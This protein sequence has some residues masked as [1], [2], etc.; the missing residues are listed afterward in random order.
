MLEKALPVLKALVTISDD[1]AQL[2]TDIHQLST[3]VSKLS[4]RLATLEGRSESLPQ[5]V[6]ALVDDRLMEVSRRRRR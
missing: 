3:N 1:I 4:E 5:V 6:K 2:R